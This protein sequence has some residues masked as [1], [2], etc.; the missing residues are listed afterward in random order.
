M[1]NKI[2]MLLDELPSIIRTYIKARYVRTPGGISIASGF[3]ILGILSAVNFDGKGGISV[4]GIQLS[5]SVSSP[6]IPTNWENVLY[7]L[8]ISLIVCGACWIFRTDH[9]QR[10]RED[11][12]NDRKVVLVVQVDAYNEVSP[13]SLSAAVPSTIK[14]K[15][16]EILVQKRDALVGGHLLSETVNDLMHI[17]SQV[18]QHATGRSLEDISVCVGGLAPVPLL[19]VLGNALE[20][21]RP[22]YWADRE[23]NTGHWV[24]SHDGV[25]TPTWDL[26]NL[27]GFSSTEVVLKSGITYPVSD[28]DVAKAFP[29]QPVVKWEPMDKLFQVILDEDSCQKICDQ[30]KALMH[31]LLAHGVRRVHLLLACSS[32]LTMRLG[33]V[34]DP[35]N[36]PELIVYQ[37]E[38]NSE[39]VYTWGVTVKSHEGRKSAIVIDRRKTT[40]NNLLY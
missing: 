27:C 15:R 14:G 7:L 30:F 25:P 24:W 18:L 2:Y 8:A 34:L 38:R 21:E 5:G 26:P 39:L 4:L 9:R 1:K 12:E 19:F 17:K 29:N 28:E 36:M 16:I 33:S 6:E 23:R 32:A 13:P 35:R 22:I 37:Y 10:K 11:E 20:D 40:A 31:L 3:G